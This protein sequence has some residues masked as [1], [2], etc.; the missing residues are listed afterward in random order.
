[1]LINL[2]EEIIYYAHKVG[3]TAETGTINMWECFRTAVLHYRSLKYFGNPEMTVVQ[4]FETES[5][6]QW[7]NMIGKD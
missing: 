5:I 4:C 6:V 1:M 2:C 3:A 7:M